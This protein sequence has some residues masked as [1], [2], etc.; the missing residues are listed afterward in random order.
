MQGLPL[1]VVLS[2]D[3]SFAGLLIAAALLLFPAETRG[4]LVPYTVFV[5]PELARV[6]LTEREARA[7]GYRVKVARLPVAAVPRAKTLHETA[8]TWKVV[9]DADT[10][11]ILG[12]AL[13]GDGSGE[14][15]SAVQVAMLGGLS[16]Q[17]V[18]DAVLTL[19]CADGRVACGKD[20]QCSLKSKLN[21]FRGLE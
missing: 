19:Q 11:L 13:L 16:Y 2:L 17:Q 10:D 4:R 14:V 9:V 1:A 7:Q 5:T 20:Y 8:G 12:A 18:R 6:G 21:D 3:G 15:I